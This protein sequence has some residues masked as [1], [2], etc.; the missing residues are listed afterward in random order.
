MEM[1]TRDS[2]KNDPMPKKTASLKFEA[3]YT[4]EE[5]EKISRG[6]IPMDMDDKFFIFCEDDILRVHH[7]WTHQCIFEIEFEH[8]Q[9]CIRVTNAIVNRNP[10]QYTTTDEAYNVKLLAFCIDHFLLGLDTPFPKSSDSQSLEGSPAH[11]GGKLVGRIGCKGIIT[12]FVSRVLSR[13]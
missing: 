9:E 12:S 7:S 5:F 1:A 2:W 3:E 10:K 6:F 11:H 8:Q 13:R 4:L